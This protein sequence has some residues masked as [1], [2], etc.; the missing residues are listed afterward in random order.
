[1]MDHVCTEYLSKYAYNSLLLL[2]VYCT[3]VT[4]EVVQS[5]QILKAN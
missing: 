1:M 2:S 4:D 5:H 3:V